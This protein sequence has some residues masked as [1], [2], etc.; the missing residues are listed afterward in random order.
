ME[1][2]PLVPQAD[3]SV[4]LNPLAWNTFANTLYSTLCGLL[5]RSMKI[6]LFVQAC[7]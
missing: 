3:G 5:A 4:A 7:S 6:F 2:G 1:N